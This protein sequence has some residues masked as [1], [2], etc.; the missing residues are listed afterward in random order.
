[1][2]ILA[3]LLQ[4]LRDPAPLMPHRVSLP[5]R[6]GSPP[7]QCEPKTPH[8]AYTRCEG[9][10]GVQLWRADTVIGAGRVHGRASGRHL[11]L[12][13][14]RIAMTALTC[15]HVAAAGDSRASYAIAGRA[16]PPTGVVPLWP[17]DGDCRLDFNAL[18]AQQRPSQPPISG[19]LGGQWGRG[20]GAGGRGSVGW[21]PLRPPRCSMHACASNAVLTNAVPGSPPGHSSCLAFLPLHGPQFVD[22]RLSL[23]SWDLP[24]APMT[25]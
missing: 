18:P 12:V 13:A 3:R 6:G 7:P 9:D 15:P 22:Q 11:E 20:A 5:R 4:R 1:M 24:T 19:A 2:S 10:T 14:R 23:G 25:T 8:L 21:P 16:L 17:W